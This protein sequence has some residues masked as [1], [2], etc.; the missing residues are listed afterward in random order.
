MESITDLGVGGILVLMILDRVVGPLMKL[1]GKKQDAPSTT[2]KRSAP[3]A[4]PCEAVELAAGQAALAKELSQGHTLLARELQA[5]A[6][7]TERSVRCLEV[8]IAKEEDAARV[9]N[10]VHADQRLLLDR[11]KREGNGQR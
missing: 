8:V 5:V 1:L 9:L 11:Q 4:Q 3:P 6:N 10:E 7:T 2:L